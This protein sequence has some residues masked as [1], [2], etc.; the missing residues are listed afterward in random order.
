MKLVLLRF[1]SLNEVFD[2]FMAKDGTYCAM[3]HDFGSPSCLNKTA[4][5][6]ATWV[7]DHTAG[8][9]TQILSLIKMLSQSTI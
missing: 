2:V 4:E 8:N 9:E 7:A 3:E 1:Q 5:E 6:V